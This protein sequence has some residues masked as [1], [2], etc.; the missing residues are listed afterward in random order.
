MSGAHLGH[1]EFLFFLILPLRRIHIPTN[2]MI[3]QWWIISTTNIVFDVCQWQRRRPSKPLRI[4]NTSFSQICAYF[5]N[6]PCTPTPHPSVPHCCNNKMYYAITNTIPK[7]CYR[8]VFFS[9][10][11]SVYS[12]GILHE[13]TF[14][15]N[16][17]KLFRPTWQL[18]HTSPFFLLFIPLD[19]VCFFPPL[20]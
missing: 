20:R 10:L 5:F 13:F 15:F 11:V 2:R 17:C 16:C 1:R 8:S 4:S 3:A 19:F 7:R 14:A 9:N 12:V 6:Q 18:N